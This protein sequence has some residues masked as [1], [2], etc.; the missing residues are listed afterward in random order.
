MAKQ[1]PSPLSDA[2]AA[3]DTELSAYTRLGELFVKTPLTSVKHLERANATLAEIAACEERLQGAG[4]R[5]VQALATARDQQ[6]Q[7]AK[8]V[9]AHVPAVQGRN[10]RLQELMT[11]LAAVRPGRRLNTLTVQRGGNR[12]RRCR[13]RRRRAQRVDDGARVSDCAARSR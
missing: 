6:E 9:V 12:A 10:K 4:Q 3:F 2:A 13:R 11:E 7:L 1:E 5:L 8:Q